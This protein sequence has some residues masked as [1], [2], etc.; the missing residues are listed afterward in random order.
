M[1]PNKW[2]PSLVFIRHY[3]LRAR[4]IK[5][6]ARLSAEVE[7]WGKWSPIECV[8]VCVYKSTEEQGVCVSLRSVSY[9]IL[10][11]Q[12]W[13]SLL[14]CCGAIWGAMPSSI[15]TYLSWSVTVF[16]IP[17]RSPACILVTFFPLSLSDS[18]QE[19]TD[20]TG[21]DV[22]EFL[23]NTLKNNPRYEIAPKVAW[24]PQL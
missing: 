17:F 16:F 21:I 14:L 6:L 4:E 15:L 9:V 23:V 8:F 13:T 3:S 22:H 18:S 2:D 10:P 7:N 1:M 12:A 19:Y 20:S 24:C 5:H 11:E